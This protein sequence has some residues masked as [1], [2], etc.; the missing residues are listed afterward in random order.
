MTE[1]DQ[2]TIEQFY[3]FIGEEKLMAAKCQNC[4]TLLIPPRPMCFKCLSTDLGWVQLKNRGRLLTYTVTYIAPQ[5][6]QSMMPYAYGIIELEDGPRLP[7]M[8]KDVNLEEMRIGMELEVDFETESSQEW[9]NWP[10]YF[11]RP[12]KLGGATKHH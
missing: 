5:Q 6:F 10:R 3:R 11:F 12:A 4:G 2:F 7:G 8:I 9:P 1:N